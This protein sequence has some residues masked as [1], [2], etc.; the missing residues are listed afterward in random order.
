MMLEIANLTTLIYS[1]QGV[2]NLIDGP[3]LM[4]IPWTSV[5][6]AIF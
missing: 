3:I 5:Y 6:K 2:E 4:Y 1:S